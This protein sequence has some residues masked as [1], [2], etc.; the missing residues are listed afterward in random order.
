MGVSHEYKKADTF[1]QQDVLT[2]LC[3]DLS[4]LS[5]TD[6]IADPKSYLAVC[7]LRANKNKHTNKSGPGKSEQS[8][9]GPQSVD[10]HLTVTNFKC[11]RIYITIYKDFF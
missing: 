9:A 1:T 4:K 11:E 10:M 2:F 7:C 6:I 8:L 3:V 5:K